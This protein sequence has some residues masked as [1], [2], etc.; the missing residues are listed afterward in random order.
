[1]RACAQ[2]K[3]SL[4]NL[5]NCDKVEF[6]QQIFNVVECGFSQKFIFCN[7]NEKEIHFG[8]GL[9]LDQPT[10]LSHLKIKWRFFFHKKM[11]S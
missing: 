11:F 9:Q 6:T 2:S 4:Q 8:N 7:N 5:K 1:M 3:S 10:I